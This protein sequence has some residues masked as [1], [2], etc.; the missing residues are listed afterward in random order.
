[1][2]TLRMTMPALLSAVLEHR[3][4]AVVL[5]TLAASLRARAAAGD[6]HQGS[7]VARRDR[8]QRS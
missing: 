2:M 5:A 1:M 8:N 4:V 7:G 3:Q 6:G